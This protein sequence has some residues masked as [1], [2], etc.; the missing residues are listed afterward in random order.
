MSERKST[1][2][3]SAG[4]LRRQA[5]EQW[6]QDDDVRGLLEERRG[7]VQRV[8]AAVSR[9]D[10]DEHSRMSD[11]VAQVD[12]QLR[13]R[14]AGDDIPSEPLPKLKRAG[15]KAAAS[16]AADDAGDDSGAGDGDNV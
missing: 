8:L 4:E 9:N 2:V 5:H 14:G 15:R 16:A 12:E 1:A 11:R 7:Y 6:R 13:A 3:L 10:A